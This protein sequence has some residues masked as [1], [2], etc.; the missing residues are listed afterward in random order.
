MK[1]WFAGDIPTHFV[2]GIPSDSHVFF[3]RQM[4][5]VSVGAACGLSGVVRDR[6]SDR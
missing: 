6:V 3:P 5:L 1:L 2:E 4:R